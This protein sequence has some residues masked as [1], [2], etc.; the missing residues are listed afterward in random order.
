MAP[1]TVYPGQPNLYQNSK[2]APSAGEALA[3]PAMGKIVNKM[4]Q[5]ATKALNHLDFDISQKDALI[6]LG[7]GPV[8]A[9]LPSAAKLFVKGGRSLLGSKIG[10][11]AGQ[12]VK[13]GLLKTHQTTGAAALGI[14]AGLVAGTAAKGLSAGMAAGRG[15]A[16]YHHKAQ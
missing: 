2:V 9:A 1:P 7:V 4:I 11:A 13:K 3:S 14:A 5:S 10:E 6:A 16:A 8:A 15:L 12:A